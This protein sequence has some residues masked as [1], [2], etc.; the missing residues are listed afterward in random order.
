MAI[1]LDLVAVLG[2][3]IL[4]IKSADRFITGSSAT[5]SNLGVAPVIIGITIVGFGTSAPEMLVAA[6]AAAGG[7][8]GMAVGNAVGSNITNIAL[9]LGGTAI[10]APLAVG[11]RLLKREY[12]VLLFVTLVACIMLAYD[13]HLGR[14]EGVVFIIMLI[15]ILF[16]L[17][18]QARTSPRKDP[19][20]LEFEQEIP[21]DIAMRESLWLLGSGLVILLVSSK[22][23]V[24]GAV[25]LAQY[26]G[27]SDLI[28]GL[29]VIAIGTSLPELAASIISVKKNEPDI[30]IG[31]IIGSN[32][33]N[34]LGVLG[35]TGLIQPAPLDPEVLQRDL[36]VMATLTLL[37]FIL[38]YGFT[39]KG[40]LT[41]VEGSILLVL[42][43]AYEVIL[44]LS[45]TNEKVFT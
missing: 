26:F 27:I 31:N 6:F 5:A 38:G 9:V 19:L 20:A 32:I 16:L 18:R 8:P 44:Y 3:F 4:L 7:N 45:V 42:F 13:K 23:L 21:H 28:I 12:P 37:L 24:W 30:A 40:H 34:T 35:I 11:S 15:V 39:R 22:L 43:L 10:M 1:L 17:I 2:G 41:R 29:T 25:N 33:F 36:P 14:L